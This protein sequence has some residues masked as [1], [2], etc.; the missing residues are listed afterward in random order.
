QLASAAVDARTDL[1]AAGVVLYELAAG[2]HPFAGLDPA[3]LMYS[4]LNER[5]EP[6]SRWNPSVSPAM[7]ATVMRLLEKEPGARL[8]SALELRDALRGAAPPAPAPPRRR[9]GARVE[10]RAIAIAAAAVA[11]VAGLAIFGRPV[12]QG[13]LGGGSSGRIRSLAVLPLE[14]L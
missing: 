4:I 10:R 6:P 8:S 12:I 14:N 2:R 3:R 11:I 1:Y 7:D 9:A 13:W 5:P